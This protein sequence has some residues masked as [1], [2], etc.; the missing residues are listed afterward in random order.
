M[1]QYQKKRLL[2]CTP[3][4]RVNLIKALQKRR[5]ISIL[6]IL[7]MLEISFIKTQIEVEKATGD[8]RITFLPRKTIYLFN[9]LMMVSA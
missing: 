1:K 4:K 5:Q 6:G 3:V 7:R 2:I 9:S 8:Q